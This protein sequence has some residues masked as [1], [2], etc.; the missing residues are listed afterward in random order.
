[1]ALRI[2]DSVIRGEIDNRLRDHVVGRIWVEGLEDPV[3]LN[4]EGFPVLGYS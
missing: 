4:L 2:A 1:M 3:R